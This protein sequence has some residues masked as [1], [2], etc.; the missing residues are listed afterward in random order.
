MA[1]GAWQIPWGRGQGLG[2]VAKAVR[3]KPN[4]NPN[5][6]LKAVGN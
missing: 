6:S 2:G 3:A 5:P 4:T 1:V